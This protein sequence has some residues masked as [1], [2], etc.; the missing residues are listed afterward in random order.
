MRF[1]AISLSASIA[2]F[3]S[4]PA[5][6][7]LLRAC[8]VTMVFMR[9][10]FILFSLTLLLAGCGSSSSTQVACDQ[11]FW[12][13]TVAVC[14]PAGWKVLDSALLSSRQVP[15]ET[16]AAFQYSTAHA[17]QIDT[18]TVVREPLSSDIDTS[19]YAEANVLAVSTLPDYKLIDKQ[20]ITIDGETSSLHVF[21]AR[22]NPS[23]PIRR[24]YQSY[25]A[26]EKMGY[27]F[28]GSFPLSIADSESEQIQ[29][30]LK[31][32]SLKDP[33]AGEKK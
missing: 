22:L 9:R 13:G 4:F 14:L 16:I 10:F 18:V 12:N 30:I 24:Y 33:T 6:S 31:N 27:T 23:E 1:L 7:S 29:F 19:A 8:R 5:V 21:S 3:A 26:G 28:T 20:T 11:Q 15:E 17:G 25:T 2:L 32:V